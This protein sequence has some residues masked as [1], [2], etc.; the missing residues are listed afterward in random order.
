MTQARFPHPN[1]MHN[2]PPPQNCSF[3]GTAQEAHAM[4]RLPLSNPTQ[5]RSHLYLAQ[6]LVDHIEPQTFHPLHFFWLAHVIATVEIRTK[7]PLPM[8]EESTLSYRYAP[9]SPA[10]SPIAT[11]RRVPHPSTRAYLVSS[12]TP[13]KGLRLQSK[14]KE[15]GSS[16]AKRSLTIPFLIPLHDQSSHDSRPHRFGEHR[17]PSKASDLKG[18]R[19]EGWLCR[20][21]DQL[22]RRFWSGLLH[23][24][25]LPS[26]TGISSLTSCQVVQPVEQLRPYDFLESQK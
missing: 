26:P 14:E 10:P 20:C 5:S 21:R 4:K 15:V 22:T 8:V 7:G 17:A 16:V 12:P 13:R 3:D 6:R 24:R 11:L 18:L 19:S 25:Y 2:V 1:R 9:S 23:E